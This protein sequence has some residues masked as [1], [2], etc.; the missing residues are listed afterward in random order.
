MSESAGEIH[1]KPKVAILA[2][3][4]EMIRELVTLYL[5][6]LSYQTIAV[7]NGR[8]AL[9]ELEKRANN[10]VELLVSDLVMPELGGAELVSEAIQNQYC[11]KVLLIS[12]Y[13]QETA[14]IERALKA[15]CQFLKK[16]FNLK[17][18]EDIVK[19][20]GTIRSE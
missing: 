8:L 14:F 15:G 20:L 10:P 1:S 9:D 16:P 3:D 4:D 12:G 7:E 6:K 18:F 11:S 17:E 19:S 2:E 5:E 13:S